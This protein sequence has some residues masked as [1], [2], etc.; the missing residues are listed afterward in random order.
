LDSKVVDVG[1]F[2]HTNCEE[3]NRKQWKISVI[4]AEVEMLISQRKVNGNQYY[5]QTMMK[6]KSRRKNP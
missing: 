6:K 5:S 4:I 2:E 3:T 1:E